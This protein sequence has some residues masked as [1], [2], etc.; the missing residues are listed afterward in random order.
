MIIKDI[1]CIVLQLRF[2]YKVINHFFY[3][4]VTLE[5]FRS[6]DAHHMNRR[7]VHALSLLNYVGKDGFVIDERSCVHYILKVSVAGLSMYRENWTTCM[8]NYFFGVGSYDHFFKLR[9]AGGSHH[10]EI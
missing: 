7:I 5:I 1:Q 2:L 8:T 3:N 9:T 4:I 10:N 6:V